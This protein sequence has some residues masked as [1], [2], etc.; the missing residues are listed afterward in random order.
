MFKRSRHTLKI[1][2]SNSTEI[3]TIKQSTKHKKNPTSKLYTK[4][5]KENIQ[6]KT[7]E[8]IIFIP[9]TENQKN[10]KLYNK[11]NKQSFKMK[12]I[13]LKE[14]KINTSFSKLLATVTEIIRGLKILFITN[15]KSVQFN[16]TLYKKYLKI[17]QFFRSINH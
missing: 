7:D 15:W 9:V 16:V 13:S 1:T 14:G 3:N 5:V 2:K 10:V 17:I 8:Y 6:L 12:A 11:K 4:K